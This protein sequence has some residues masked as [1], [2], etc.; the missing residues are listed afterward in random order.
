[1]K[2]CPF[3]AEEIQDK[4]IVCKHC[5][6]D[7][8]ADIPVPAPMDTPKKKSSSNGIAIILLIVLACIVFGIYSSTRGG[9][10]GGAS[11]TDDPN[12]SAWYACQLFIK[13][14]LKAPSTADFER[15]SSSRV[16]K[17]TDGYHV[18][19]YVDA[20]NSFGAK[21][22]S[23]FSCVVIKNGADWRLVDLKTK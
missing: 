12:S 14:N 7:L 17:G 5:K 18:T 11:P 6:R 3:C 13:Q 20:Q 8:V 1:M 23:N 21:I 2:K 22:R 15:Y 10:S 19:M 16:F 9:G 4:A